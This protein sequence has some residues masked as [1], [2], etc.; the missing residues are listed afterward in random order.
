MRTIDVSMPIAPGMPGFPGDPTVAVQPT[1]RIDRG[2]PYDLSTWT[3]GSHVGTHVDPPSHFVRGGVTTDQLDLGILNGP[4]A[5]VDVDPA[6]RV[7]GPA[8][9]ARIPA[10]TVRVLFRTG[11]SLRWAR[12]ERFFPDYVALAPDAAGPLLARGV[13]LVGIDALSVELDESGKFPVH[14]ALLGGGALVLEGLRLGETPAGAYELRCLP[15]RLVG[16]DGGPCR[17]VLLAP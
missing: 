3:F 6:S 11:N 10:G 1:R 4:C 5:V 9:V 8:D 16:G 12:E 17:A 15:L 13:R 14:H 2:D 7:V